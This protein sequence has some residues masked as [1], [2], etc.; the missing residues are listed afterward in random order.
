MS[1]TVSISEQR[2]ISVVKR[3]GE[4]QGQ[5]NKTDV[6]ILSS[7]LVKGLKSGGG[8]G[9][10]GQTAAGRSWRSSHALSEAIT[11]NVQSS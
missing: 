1:M 5:L 7:S 4:T 6:D 3:Q 2:G 9:M 11:N 10:S 8:D